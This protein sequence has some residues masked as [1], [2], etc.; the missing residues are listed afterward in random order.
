MRLIYEIAKFVAA[1]SFSDFSK[2]DI[3]ITKDSV[4]DCLGAMIGGW[5]EPVS[6]MVIKYIKNGGVGGECVVVGGGFQTSLTNAAFIHG[7]T[8]HALE[9]ESLGPAPTLNPM[10]CI[11]PA[12]S[13]GEKFRLSG[14]AVIEGIV[15]GLEVQALLG[16]TC[17][18]ASDKG[19]APL[20]VFGT[21]GAAVTAGKMLKLNIEQMQNALSLAISQCCGLRRQQG[22]L[23]HLLDSGIACRNGLTAALLAR[24]GLTGN[25]ELMEGERGFFDLF[26][27]GSSEVQ[28]G[29]RT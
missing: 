24:E 5:G 23:A 3:K 9:L 2:D 19:F 29:S 21:I 16:K 8:A 1:K 13:V 11:P 15:I 6:Q 27:P 14:K 18:S 17:A 12:L 26:C 7:V 4:L 28:R 10:T 20:T 22:T 25:P